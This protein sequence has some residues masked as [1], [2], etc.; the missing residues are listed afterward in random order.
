MSRQ[1]YPIV[2]QHPEGVTVIA[3]SNVEAYEVASNALGQDCTITSVEKIHEGGVGGFF[4]TELVK[5]NAKRSRPTDR[6]RNT[7]A[8]FASA[9]DLVSSLRTKAPNFADRLLDEWLEESGR[10]F[11]RP[12]PDSE[13]VAQSR[14]AHPSSTALA[15]AK[16]TQRLAP[17]QPLAPNRCAPNA[18]AAPSP[19]IPQPV[20]NRRPAASGAQQRQIGHDLTTKPATDAAPHRVVDKRWSQAALRSVGVPDRVVDLAMSAGPVTE[21]EW[22]VALMR[23]LR[24]YCGPALAIPT[25]M[26]GPSC[27][28]LARQLR[29]VSVG[30]EELIE[31]VSSVAVPNGGARAVVAGLNGRS[32][33]LVVGGGSHPLTGVEVHVVSAADDADI[34]EALRV[35]VAWNATLGW[36][37]SGD[38][39]ERLDEFT[40]VAHVRELLGASEP[41]LVSS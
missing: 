16:A 26:V 36:Y 19:P 1:S 24:G 33:H 22:I 12:L 17:E 32:V 31:T 29:L 14:L 27:A 3:R 4:A 35:C 39:Y 15:P 40:V 28:N 6:R 13:G 25:V 37:W 5:V 34:F 30:P 2:E 20:S 21:G 18:V 7:D 41:V 8:V 38:R 10:E 9:Q 23:A 11:D